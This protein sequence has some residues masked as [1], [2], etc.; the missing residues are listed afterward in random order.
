MI[1][2]G[3][4]DGKTQKQIAEAA[5]M[6]QPDVCN[7]IKTSK[8][9][10]AAVNAARTQLQSVTQITRTDVINGVMEAIDM[11][12][13]CADPGVMIKG[14]SE[15]AKMLGHYAPE[16]K[17]IELTSGQS[18]LSKKLEGLSDEE[19]MAIAE[20]KHIVDGEFSEIH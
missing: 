2:E 3:I 11:A 19:L 8:D 18:N 7:A 12:R 1:A 14:W 4:L 13:L 5:G 9:V 16:V 20:G 17:K 10:A 15:I 6:H